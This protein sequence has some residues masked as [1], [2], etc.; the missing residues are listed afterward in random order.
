M[1]ELVGQGADLPGWEIVLLGSRTLVGR[2]V[3]GT[4]SLDPV[5]ELQRATVMTREGPQTQV[6][7][8]PVA[9]FLSLT[10]IE[11]DPGAVSVFPADRLSKQERVWLRGM[12]AEAQDRLQKASAA[13]AGVTIAKQMPA[14]RG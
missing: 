2:R 14:G 5:Y 9:G 12:I 4:M 10:R 6:A 7:L 1:T 8:Q 13:Q 3:A 11:I